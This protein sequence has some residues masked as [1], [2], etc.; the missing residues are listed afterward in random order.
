MGQLVDTRPQRTRGV[1]LE[2]RP[3]RVDAPPMPA[4]PSGAWLRSTEKA[5]ADL[6][7]SPI[8]QIIDRKSD[9]FRL[10]R[11]AA[12]L[13]EWQR[14]MR[15]YRRQRLVMGSKGQVMLNPL[16][17]AV[18]RLEGELRR[19]EERFGLTPLDRLALGISYAGARSALAD[20]LAEL[21]GA[22]GDEFELPESETT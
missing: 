1:I 13:D 18:L 14:A 6:W 2:L 3:A 8:A 12:L 21:E 7:A 20:M 9:M 22:A 5:W 17:R 16:F 19:V 4:A 15:G 10:S 11:W